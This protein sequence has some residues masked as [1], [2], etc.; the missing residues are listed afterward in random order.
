[1][2]KILLRFKTIE[3]P[4]RSTFIDFIEAINVWMSRVITKYHP[5]VYAQRM[6][7]VNLLCQLKNTLHLKV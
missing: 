7:A 1:M 2:S 3:P 5:L 4:N 6:L